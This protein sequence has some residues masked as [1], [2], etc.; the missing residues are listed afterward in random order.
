M[1][2]IRRDIVRHRPTPSA[3]GN[4]GHNQPVSAQLSGRGRSV[5][6]SSRA[7]VSLSGAKRRIERFAIH[8]GAHQ[9]LARFGVLDYYGYETIVIKFRA[10]V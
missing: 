10:K 5:R 6:L 7:A 2:G 9:D 8:K 4:P 3:A 1:T